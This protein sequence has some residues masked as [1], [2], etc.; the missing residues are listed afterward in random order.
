MK[1]YYVYIMTNISRTLY[2][3]ITGDLTRRVFEHKAKAVAGFTHRYNITR[4]AYFETTSDVRAALEREKQ[5]K[6]W[7]RERKLALIESA[8]PEW[9]DLSAEWLQ[10]GGDP[11]L[12]SG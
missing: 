8:N 4:L 7:R 10:D 12:R 11:S 5:L 2:I 9:E 6:G 1:T 3:G